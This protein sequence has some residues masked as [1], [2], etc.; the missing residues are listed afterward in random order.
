MSGNLFDPDARWLRV[1]TDLFDVQHPLHPVNTGEPACRAF[2]WLDLLA[3]ARWKAGNGLKRGELR[4]SVRFLAQ[5][6]NRSKTWAADFLRELEEEH[7]VIERRPGNGPRVPA[8]LRI[9]D[10]DLIVQE[11]GHGDGHTRGRT[12]T[13]DDTGANP[14]PSGSDAPTADA[15]A[16]ASDAADARTTHSRT[17][18]R[19]TGRRTNTAQ[20]PPGDRLHTGPMSQG[21]DAP[22]DT[23]RTHSRTRSGTKKHQHQEETPAPQSSKGSSLRSSPFEAPDGRLDVDNSRD[24]NGKS[25]NERLAPAIREH[26]YRG[27]GPP[28]GWSIDRCLSRARQLLDAGYSVDEI[29]DALCGLRWMVERSHEF[30]CDA[31]GEPLIRP[32]Q[33]FRVI[34]FNRAEER[35]MKLLSLA[36]HYRRK[37]HEPDEERKDLAAVE[38]VLS[39]NQAN[40]GPKE[41]A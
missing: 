3:Y 9:S 33:K 16:D 17:R 8:T 41:R 29:E 15:F 4:A 39:P 30:I 6:W 14:S 36:A 34:V 27:D 5:R 31:S 20:V 21:A 35:G 28:G 38:P 19:R 40:G 37:H 25:W 12:E 24:D 26:A 22:V 18:T 2:A 7:G 1:G 10:Y 11:P 23:K 13:I 32:G